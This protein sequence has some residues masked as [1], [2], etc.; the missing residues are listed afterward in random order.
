[1]QQLELTLLGDLRICRGKED[2]THQLPKK[3]Q[4]LLAYLAVTQRQHRRAAL[5][6]L[7]WSDY[8][9][10]RARKNLRDVLSSLRKVVGEWLVISRTV[11][12][13]SETAVYHTDV[14]TFLNA[15]R[16]N[17]NDNIKQIEQAEKMYRGEFLAGFYVKKAAI[18]EEWMINQ[19]EY[20][21]QQALNAFATLTNHYISQH[22]PD[23]GI[24]TAQHLLQMDPWRE[25]AHRQL[26]QLLAMDGQSSAALKQY[27]LCRQTLALELGVEPSPKTNSLFTKIKNGAGFERHANK[28]KQT[29][30][31]ETKQHN[32]PP[33]L[34]SFIGRQAEQTALQNY[35]EDDVTRLIT[36]VGMGGIGKTRLAI[37][38]ARRQVE[39]GRFPDGITF[40]PLHHVTQL[41]HLWQAMA[42]ALDYPLNNS[43]SSQQQLTT[44]LHQKNALLIL[45]NFEQLLDTT[46]AI[47]ALLQQTR[48][49]QLIVTSRERL[50]VQAEQ[51]IWLNGLPYPGEE[52]AVSTFTTYPAYQLLQSR[53]QRAAPGLQFTPGHAHSMQQ[54]CRL[55]DGMPLAIELAAAWADT[56]SLTE[57]ASEITQGLYLLES[58]LQDVAERH[59][60]ITA[61]FDH[62]WNRLLPDEQTLFSKLSL[63]GNNFL[64][65]DAQAITDVTHRQFATLTQKSLLQ[66]DQTRSRYTIHPLL[67]QYG[68]QKADALPVPQKSTIREEHSHYY[69]HALQKQN[70][71]LKGAQQ[72]EILN[73][74]RAELP[75]IRIAWA[76]ACQTRNIQRIRNTHDTVGHFCLNGGRY[77]LGIELFKMAAK[78]LAHATGDAQETQALCLGWQAMFT[79]Q[80]GDVAA[81]EKLLNHAWTLLQNPDLANCDTRF[82]RAFLLRQLGNIASHKK[83]Y[84]DAIHHY[85]HALILFQQLEEL[86]WMGATCQNLGG[87]FA[88]T[89]GN[90]EKAIPI[91]EQGLSCFRDMQDPG[92]IAWMLLLMHGVSEHNGRFYTAEQQCNEALNIFKQT[93]N[94]HEIAMVE[95]QLGLNYFRQGN[96]DAAKTML[97]KATAVYRHFGHHNKQY[98]IAYELGLVELHQGLYDDAAHRWQALLNTPDAQRWHNLVRTAVAKH[99]LTTG[100]IQ[101]AQWQLE[102]A[103]SNFNPTG[104]AQERNETYATTIYLLPHLNHDTHIAVDAIQ[105]LAKEQNFIRLLT[106][107]PAIANWQLHIDAVEQAITTYTLASQYPFVANSRW[108]AD[109]VG[110]RIAAATA[111]L[112]DDVVQLAKTRGEKSDFGETAV[113]LLHTL[114][115]KKERLQP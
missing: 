42:D 37:A 51:A 102:K 56:L 90:F 50:H 5:A 19:R 104:N 52:T 46:P 14:H 11:V 8:P 48:H 49:L 23:K 111:K 9:E 22:Q 16:P 58:N 12:S 67:H 98:R 36:I 13:M 1:M 38:C 78:A 99:A 65:K 62:T 54:I 60:R 105:T 17:E 7:L 31:T 89:L 83:A 21:H 20:M 110:E 100:N 6:G 115:T 66:P 79:R 74:I 15:L 64:R 80:M 24:P 96:Y 69:C 112:P 47:V 30:Q 95:Q 25:S 75:N 76:W 68:Q 57:I 77:R 61:V 92:G 2:L 109:V 34:T 73:N 26:M 106:A 43:Q 28:R 4:A 40:I 114:E 53:I 84:T 33:D 72:T 85:E 101:A 108:F 63:F 35:L 44:F 45:D 97:E 81:S 59:K 91:M 88:Y 32:L 39:N 71:P 113:S 103:L 93:G 55:L 70:E 3:A 87:T 82:S 94:R 18:F 41:N 107:L 27:D 29:D 10:Q 86:T